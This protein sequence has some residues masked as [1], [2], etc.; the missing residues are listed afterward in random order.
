MNLG[1]NQMHRLSVLPVLVLTVYENVKIS[2]KWHM[3][4]EK[5]GSER[6]KTV[7][8][9]VI[10]NKPVLT[11]WHHTTRAVVLKLGPAEKA[12][13]CIVVGLNVFYLE[14]ETIGKKD[15]ALYMKCRSFLPDV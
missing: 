6:Q 10:G 5:K 15:M 2:R 9:D 8:I 13:T 11:L 4:K 1:P 14:K 12:T 7:T 3:M